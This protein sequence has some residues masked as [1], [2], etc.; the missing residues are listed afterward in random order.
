MDFDTPHTR[1]AASRT[2]SSAPGCSRMQAGSSQALPLSP[3]PS[4]AR[5]N[6]LLYSAALELRNGGQ[7]VE[8]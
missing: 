8:L 5:N 3:R 7:N 2:S 1:A 6:A 4:E